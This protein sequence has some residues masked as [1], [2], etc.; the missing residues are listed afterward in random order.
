MIKPGYN[1]NPQE[2][3][4]RVNELWGAASAGGTGGTWT[5]A[6]GA[7][8]PPLLGLRGQGVGPHPAPPALVTQGL[9][10]RSSPATGSSHWQ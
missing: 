10:H 2:W 1:P 4:R 3:Q 9:S 5:P 8:M 7:V 6:A